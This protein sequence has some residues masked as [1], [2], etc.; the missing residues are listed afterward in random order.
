MPFSLP[1]ASARRMSMR[2]GAAAAEGDLVLLSVARHERFRSPRGERGEIGKHSMTPFGWMTKRSVKAVRTQRG[3]P[4]LRFYRVRVASASPCMIPRRARAHRA[5]AP[6]RPPSSRLPRRGG[7][8]ARP[9]RAAPATSAGV[10]QLD[11]VGQVEV[12]AGEA[13]VEDAHDDAL[14]SPTDRRGGGGSASARAAPPQLRER[15]PRRASSSSSFARLATA[16]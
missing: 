5:R 1:C 12:A 10:D 11:S 6:R 2:P 13:L 15:P 14:L 4:S 8:A 3:Q 9:D 7:R 16:S